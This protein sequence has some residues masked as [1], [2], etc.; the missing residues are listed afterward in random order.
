MANRESIP[1]LLNC[2]VCAE[3]HIDKGEFATRI[4]HTHACQAC[5]TVWR[6]AIVATV[7]VRFLPGFRNLDV[8]DSVDH[9]ECS[10]RVCH[11]LQN[12]NV[13]TIQDLCNLGTPAL[14]SMGLAMR[15][16]KE[17]DDELEAKGFARPVAK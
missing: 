16:V 13:K 1:M 3:R 9:L 6:P 12:H 8:N 4:H 15:H 10:I 5:G 17:I 7:G 2:P 14:Q 11:A